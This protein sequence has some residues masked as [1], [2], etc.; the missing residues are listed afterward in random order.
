LRLLE[1]N[2]V[3]YIV[4]G[5]GTFVADR[6]ARAGAESLLVLDGATVP[7]LF[8][9]RRGLEGE[10]AALAA[11]RVNVG[12]VQQLRAIVQAMHELDLDDAGYVSL[13]RDL[14][15]SVAAATRNRFFVRFFETIQQMFI[16]YSERVIVLPGR[17]EHANVGHAAIVE[18]I[19]KK[20][21]TA[22]R[23]AMVQH[24]SS[25]EQDILHQLRTR[26]ERAA[27]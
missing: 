13:D 22:A 12:E 4:H 21:S 6:P 18:A 1:A 5:V 15:A 24:L 3:V 2:G 19:A 26:P 23:S 14:H 9:I 10:A 17:R 27:R 11:K 7:E 20:R 16:D 8:D 25:A